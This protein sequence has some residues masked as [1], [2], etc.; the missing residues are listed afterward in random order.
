MSQDV[1]PEVG[2]EAYPG[3]FGEPSGGSDRGV[4]MIPGAGHGPFGDLFLRDHGRVIEETLA[5]VGVGST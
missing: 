2:G 1:T 4:L 5:P 3:R